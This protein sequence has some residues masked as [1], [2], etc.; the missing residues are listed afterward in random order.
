MM[1]KKVLFWD[2]DTQFDFMSTE[3]KLSVRGADKIID[4]VS[5]VRKFALDNGYSIIASTDWHS[6]DNVE[7]SAKPD[8]KTTF[9][10]HCI[11]STPGAE[12]VGFLGDVPI[13]YIDMNQMPRDKL[14]EMLDKPQFHIVLRKNTLD[15]FGNPNTDEIL[16]LVNPQTVVVYGIA[17]DFCV[18]MLVFDL[19][20]RGKADV[21]VLKDAVA[22]LGTRPDDE[23]YDEFRA[24]G[25]KVQT[26]DDLKH[27]SK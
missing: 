6:L 18:S 24:K 16:G 23:L 7:I 2:V 14:A 8:Y 11:V 3:G 9:P 20:R 26:L 19:L 22:R 12:R 21:T 25:V 17:L 4:R 15:I 10:P 5:A 27:L 13:D 1:E